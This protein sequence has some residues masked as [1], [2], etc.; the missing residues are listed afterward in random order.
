M[1]ERLNILIH[2]DF[3]RALNRFRTDRSLSELDD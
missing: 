3:Q 1:T 2:G